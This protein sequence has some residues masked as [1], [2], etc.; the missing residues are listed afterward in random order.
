MAAIQGVLLAAVVAATSAPAAEPIPA[1]FYPIQSPDADD[2]QYIGRLEALLRDAFLLIERRGVFR[3]RR[4]L[5]VAGSCEDRTTT[6]CLA[7]LAG[8]NGAIFFTDARERAEG[9]Q[10]TLW[11]ISGAGKRSRPVQFLLSPGVLDTRGPY[12]ALAL[13][14]TQAE[15]LAVNLPPPEVGAD[16]VAAIPSSPEA[17]PPASTPLASSPAAA[18]PASAPVAAADASVE[19]FTESPPPVN[20][21]M[22]PVGIGT[23]LGGLAL[24]GGGLAF[25]MVGTNLSDDLSE[26]FAT[27]AL[28]PSDRALYGRVQTYAL[29]ANT[30]MIGG[31]VLAATGVTLWGLTPSAAPSPS[32]GGGRFSLMGRF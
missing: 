2:A 22:R 13:L 20:Q 18:G 9:T 32:Y 8:R 3:A 11:L 29:V 6:A 7:G 5:F 26:K 25:G 1:A 24:F 31:A 27:N 23:S 30:M 14:E 15:L 12:D 17:P 10:V 28:R 21:W 19:R 16:A 4:P